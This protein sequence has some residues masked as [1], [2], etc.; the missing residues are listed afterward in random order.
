MLLIKCPYCGDRAEVE[1]ANGGEA[2]IARPADPSTLSDE[3]WAQYLYMRDNP[4]GLIAER[5]RHAHGCGRFF[6]AIR[7]TRTDRFV[8]TYEMGQPRPVVTPE[9]AAEAAR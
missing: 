6:N 8:T 3:E 1:F 5:W 2:H 4:K 7:D 9:Q